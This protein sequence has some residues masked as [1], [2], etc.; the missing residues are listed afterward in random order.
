MI[1]WEQGG[2]WVT[3]EQFPQPGM[4]HRRV[5]LS[6]TPSGTTADSVHDGSLIGQPGDKAQLTV[7]PGLTTACSRD[8]AQ[9]SAGMGAVF[10]ACAKDS[11]IAERGALTFTSAPVTERTVISGP[12]NVHLNTV[13]DAADGY[14]SVTVNDVS[15]DG[16][17]TVLSTG[18]L[19]A[20]LRAIDE[21]RST[22]SPNGDLTA[23][24]NPITLDSVQPVTPGEPV[25]LD[26]A[27]IPTQAA[28]EPGHRLR[29]DVFAANA[30]KAL[31]FRP[32]LN[33]TELKPQHLALDPAAPSFVNLPTDRPQ[34]PPSGRPGAAPARAA[35]PPT[36]PAPQTPPPPPPPP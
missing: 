25:A 2:G 26:I 36:P 7:A 21:A 28:L 31:A 29:L 1:V 35:R 6:G 32:M 17:S 15:P 30:P 18:Q 13:H 33:D 3:L 23:P 19:T 16:T 27:V 9:G 24:F 10:D 11:R 12:I 22:R 5:Y 20:S 14:W 8:M 34:P 4:T